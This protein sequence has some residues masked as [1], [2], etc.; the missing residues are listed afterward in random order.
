VLTIVAAVRIPIEATRQAIDDTPS[1][2][3]ID[4][5]RIAFGTKHHP[6]K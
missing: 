3:P 5:I 1:M 4:P 2:G 6:D